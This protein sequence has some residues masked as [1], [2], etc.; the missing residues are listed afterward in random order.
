MGGSMTGMHYTLMVDVQL[1][2]LRFRSLLTK[3]KSFAYQNKQATVEIILKMI[4][5]VVD[6]NPTSVTFNGIVSP[7][8]IERDG[9][10]LT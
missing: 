4:L 1:P 6:G 8:A 5:R 7:K 10:K 9:Q 3:I 2:A